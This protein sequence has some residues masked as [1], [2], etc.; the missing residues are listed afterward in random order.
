MGFNSAFKGLIMP[1]DVCVCNA[2]EHEGEFEGQVCE[3][4]GKYHLVKECSL[5]TS[6]FPPSRTLEF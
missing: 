5:N 6:F 1:S 3:E 2:D 4:L